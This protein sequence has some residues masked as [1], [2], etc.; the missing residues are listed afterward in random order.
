MIKTKIPKSVPWNVIADGLKKWRGWNLE[1]NT[2]KRKIF[3][4]G[5]E[6]ILVVNVMG[7]KWKAEYFFRNRLQDTTGV[8]DKEFVK[9]LVMEMGFLR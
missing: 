3:V 7:K 2:S 1:E 6:K 4:R 9:S 5:N 8:A